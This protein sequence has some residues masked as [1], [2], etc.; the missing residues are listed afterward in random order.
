MP[1]PPRSVDSLLGGHS[2]GAE[3]LFH[4]HPAEPG[5]PLALPVAPG[6]P[7]PRSGGDRSVPGRPSASAPCRGGTPGT[8][9]AGRPGAATVTSRREPSNTASS[10][11]RAGERLMGVGDDDRSRRSVE[12]LSGDARPQG[13]FGHERR[14]DLEDR[15]ERDRGRRDEL[16]RIGEPSRA[17]ALRNGPL[18]PGSGDRFVEPDRMHVREEPGGGVAP[19]DRLVAL[20][21]DQRTGDRCRHRGDQPAPQ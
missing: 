21:F 2:N 18:A 3:R 5:A 4:H 7:R 10:R 13:R 19:H 17:R 11:S 8:P 9:R 12:F 14:G 20:A 1:G 15:Q 16:L 6:D